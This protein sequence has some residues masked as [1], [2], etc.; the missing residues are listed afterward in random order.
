MTDNRFGTQAH[1]PAL[2][3]QPVSDPAEWLPQQLESDKRWM[4]TL[5]GSDVAHLRSMLARLD[6][7]VAKDPNRLMAIPR[8]GFDFGAFTARLHAMRE[9]LK[10]GYGAVLIRGLPIQEFSRAELASIYWGIG[11]HLGNAC[12]N[13]PEGDMIGHVTD[14][15]KTQ[16]D[17]HSRGYET[18]EDMWFHCDQSSIV[19][20]LCVRTSKS[21]GLSKISSSIAMYNEILRRDP[22]AVEVLSQPFSWTKHGEMD[23]GEKGFYESPVFNFLDGKLCTSF[24]PTHIKKG[25]E[26]AGATPMST[27]QAQ[28]IELAKRVAEEQHFG[29]QLQPGDMQFLNN[30][31]TLHTR[32]EY[33][34][35]PEP[36]RKRLMWR[37]WLIDSDLRPLTPYIQQWQKG[38]KLRST[39][40]RIVV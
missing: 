5:D 23:A 13:N 12:S 40:E 37:L 6:P 22:E 30:L 27:K 28:A 21:G 18:R 39:T 1:A 17:P 16:K 24:G 4:Y 11:R 31:V 15:G 2:K 20:L 38:V 8:E 14:K 26:V 7:E 10:N 25:H 33:E 32:N 3:G 9:E 35:W 29:M 36:D 19:G 34:D